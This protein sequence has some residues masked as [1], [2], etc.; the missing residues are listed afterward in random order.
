MWCV[1][2]ND[3]LLSFISNLLLTIHL[4]VYRLAYREWYANDFHITYSRPFPYGDLSNTDTS[5]IRTVHLVPGKCLYIVKTTSI[6]Q[7][8]YNTDNG[9]EISAPERKFLQA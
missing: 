1:T 5:L 4:A 2:G 8:L 3:P 6:I 7:T 9:H